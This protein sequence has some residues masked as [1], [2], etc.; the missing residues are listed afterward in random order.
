MSATVCVAQTGE[1]PKGI[2]LFGEL[3]RYGV[4]LTQDHKAH[5]VLQ[6]SDL[7]LEAIVNGTTHVLSVDTMDGIRAWGKRCRCTTWIALATDHA[8]QP[9]ISA[10]GNAP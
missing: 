9:S 7:L 10:T 6:T 5:K 4:A 8:S 2:N 1:R 3:G